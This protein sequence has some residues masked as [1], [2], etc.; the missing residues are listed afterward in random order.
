M[1]L[2]YAFAFSAYGLQAA[3]LVGKNGLAPANEFLA[4]IRE[5][6]GS[7]A[8]LLVPSIF[9][10]NQDDTFIQ[11]VAIAGTLLGVAC[12]ARYYCLPF[13]LLM[14]FFYLSITTTGDEFMGFQW[15]AL[16]LESGFL[17][18][19][20]APLVP[21]KLSKHAPCAPPAGVIW[22]L[23][24]L[25]FRLMFMSG[26]VKLS[27]GDTSWSDL[28]AMA[29]HYETQPLPNPI[30]WFL[31]K[32]PLAYHQFET[33]MVL[34]IEIGVPFLIFGTRAMRHVAAVVLI[35][36]QILI[37]LTGNFAFFNWLTIAICITLLDDF[38]IESITPRSLR[39]RR[40][41]RKH[42]SVRPTKQT[43]ALIV[44][45]VIIVFI[46]TLNVLQLCRMFGFGSFINFT[47]QPAVKLQ[48]AF[49]LVNNYGLFAVMTK[50]R[51]EIIIEGS[52]DKTNWKEY[53]F[54]FKAGDLRRPPPF[55]APY[56]PRLDWQM[57]F[58]ALQGAEGTQLVEEKW[59]RTLLMKLLQADPYA[60]SLLSF[61]P[62]PSKPPL[63]LRATLYDYN[64]TT[65]E[66]LSRT[67]HWWK[68]TN[69]RPYVPPLSL[70]EILAQ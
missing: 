46:G 3:A 54:P 17:A 35:L 63:Y 34:L 49:H 61:N 5:V 25:V 52:N 57:W 42:R 1:G 41:W 47:L 15:D 7:E 43:I 9:W 13:F 2:V 66:E 67:G 39:C 44:S 29:Y 28:T 60:L 53:Q 65:M 32:M 21:P 14:W 20:T 68:R 4:A 48:H 30:A 40:R 69:P 38:A 37:M 23:R 10:F 64:F 6:R 50:T 55:V 45:S 12:A 36:L 18:A 19:F 56:Q 58:A 51:P 16:L 31:H 22:L 11:A 26:C 70:E 24:F 27:S 62:F 8:M 33:G 59:L